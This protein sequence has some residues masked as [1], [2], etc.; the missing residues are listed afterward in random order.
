MPRQIMRFGEPGF[1]QPATVIRTQ[2]TTA[3]YALMTDINAYGRQ[4]TFNVLA[5]GQTD[6]GLRVT[7]GRGTGRTGDQSNDFAVA[8]E[9]GSS[10]AV[11]V[12]VPNK[13]VEIDVAAG[14]LLS[15]LKV[16][17]D[18]ETELSSTYFGGE[19]GTN[20]VQL[21]ESLSY[22]GDDDAPRKARFK[23]SEGSGYVFFGDAA[24]TDNLASV[25]L[26]GR[27]GA[28][29]GHIPSGAKVYIRHDG[30]TARAICGEVFD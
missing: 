18:A 5:D 9:R 1:P 12:G 22:G 4:A 26:I 17:I 20:E 28:W 11:S 19:T 8:V 21:R 14:A 2:A 29:T 24:A 25:L 7:I 3:A 6:Q 16:V 15:A 27:A 30:G 10:S 13:V 23:I